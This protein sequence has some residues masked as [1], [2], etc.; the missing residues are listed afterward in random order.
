MTQYE[1][2]KLAASVTIEASYYNLLVSRWEPFLE[3]CSL[4]ATIINNTNSNP[5]SFVSLEMNENTPVLNLNL[6]KELILLL[7]NT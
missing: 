6:S 4:T 3:Y 5:R 7:L 1:N 2:L